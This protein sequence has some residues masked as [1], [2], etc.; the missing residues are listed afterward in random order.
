V[1]DLARSSCEAYAEKMAPE[2]EAKYPG[3]GLV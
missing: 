1:R 3:W 2:W